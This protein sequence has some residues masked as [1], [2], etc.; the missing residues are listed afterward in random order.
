MSA[1]RIFNRPINSVA[2]GDYQRCLY[3]REDLPAVLNLSPEQIGFLIDTGQ[4]TAILICGEERFDSREVSA[5]I[6]TYIRV[7]RRRTND[8]R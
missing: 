4:L 1:R 5:L 3:M 6:E 8:H 7:T 2:H